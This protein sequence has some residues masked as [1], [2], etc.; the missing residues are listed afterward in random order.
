M[1][2]EYY[3]KK[4]YNSKYVSSLDVNVQSSYTDIWIIYLINLR[5]KKI[6]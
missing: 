2:V 3:I 4:V 1:G 6:I 5:S